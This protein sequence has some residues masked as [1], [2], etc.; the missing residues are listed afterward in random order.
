MTSLIKYF[1]LPT[2]ALVI[3]L[4]YGSPSLAQTASS[5]V[6]V[7]TW[8]NMNT[9]GYVHG[10]GQAYSTQYGGFHIEGGGNSTAQPCHS[11]V[12]SRSNGGYG[13]RGGY[14]FQQGAGIQGSGS[15]GLNSTTHFGAEGSSWTQFQW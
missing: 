9:N 1:T 14:N 11:C 12:E 5:H 8:N 15:F 13:F 7:G 3:G 6:K 10:N 2:T 4:L